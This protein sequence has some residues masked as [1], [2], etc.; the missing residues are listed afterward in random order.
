MGLDK[1]LPGRGRRSKTTAWVI[2][3]TDC[4]RA[5]KGRSSINGNSPEKG[6]MDRMKRDHG[7][8]CLELPPT[9]WLLAGAELPRSRWLRGHCIALLL[10]GDFHSVGGD[11]P[12]PHT[13]PE[14]THWGGAG[15]GHGLRTSSPASQGFLPPR[16]PV[17]FTLPPPQ[18]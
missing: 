16:H 12:R 4:H 14:R 7:R 8:S 17:P 5:A 6:W 9:A 1:A 2:C 3:T 11:N 18:G 13:T 10:P 15:R